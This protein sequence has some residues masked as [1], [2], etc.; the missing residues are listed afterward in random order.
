MAETT[1][2]CVVR[3]RWFFLEYA[4]NSSACQRLSRAS[5]RVDGVKT[6]TH[7]ESCRVEDKVVTRVEKWDVENP[8]LVRAVCPPILNGVGSNRPHRELLLDEGGGKILREETAA[9]SI[10]AS[11]AQVTISQTPWLT[12]HATFDLVSK[13]DRGL[14]ETNFTRFQSDCKLAP[15]R[16]GRKQT[17]VVDSVWVS[18]LLGGDSATAA[19]YVS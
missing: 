2:L 14:Y 12:L 10:A 15:A 16:K 6:P 13:V 9:S 3:E 1:G 8:A 4:L 11:K 18:S 7:S 19:T 17:Q 5:P